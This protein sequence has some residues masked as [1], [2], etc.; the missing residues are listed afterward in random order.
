MYRQYGILSAITQDQMS[1]MTQYEMKKAAAQV[2]LDYVETGT[3]IGTGSNASAS[4]PTSAR[5]TS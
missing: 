4:P 5:A 2:A 3:I 1:I